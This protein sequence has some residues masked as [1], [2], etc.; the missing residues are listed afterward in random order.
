VTKSSIL[1]GLAPGSTVDTNAIQIFTSGFDSRGRL[2]SPI[3]QAIIIIKT[4]SQV[5]LVLSIKNVNQDLFNSSS[6][7]N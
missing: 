5:N 1:S 2:L 6:N 3:T 7:S 4:T